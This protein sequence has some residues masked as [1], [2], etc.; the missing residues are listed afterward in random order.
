MP[1]P[2][3]K[4]ERSS[5]R[6]TRRN[7]PSRLM[8]KT[9]QNIKKYEDYIAKN[10]VNTRARNNIADYLNYLGKSK[11]VQE[12]NGRNQ[13]QKQIEKNFNAKR[14]LYIMKA[15]YNHFMQQPQ[16]YVGQS[17]AGERRERNLTVAPRR[18]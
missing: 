3:R 7:S 6:G 13:I 11:A 2:T 8:N 1:S 12:N 10:P 15:N 5:N 4:R 9:K 18:K 16:T 14:T 17:P